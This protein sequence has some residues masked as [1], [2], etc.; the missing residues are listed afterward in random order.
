M[1]VIND[2]LP[3]ADNSGNTITKVLVISHGAA[4]DADAHDPLQDAL[5]DLS[6]PI[7]G[8]AD[9]E[10]LEAYR[11]ALIESAKKLNTMRRLTEAYQREV[12]RAIGGTPAAST[13][14]RVG[15]VKQRG[16][17]IASMLGAD[18]LVYASPIENLRAA[19]ATTDE[20][21]GLDGKERRCMMKRVQQL[22]NTAATRQE[23]GA[24]AES[25]AP[26]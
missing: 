7:A 18:C 12:D 8:D 3:R 23:A 1:V 21:E 20:L 14:S 17:A 6:M 2:Q 10:A 15:A 24:H 11:L 9:A 26:R 5:H 16:V 22:I 19:Q 13:P 25:P 4:S